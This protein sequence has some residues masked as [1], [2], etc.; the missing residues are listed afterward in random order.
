MRLP[1]SARRLHL[2]GGRLG[3]LGLERHALD[4]RDRGDAG[5]DLLDAVIPQRAGAAA[6]GGVLDLRGGGARA[7]ELANFVIEHEQLKGAEA[8]AVSRLA[9]VRA[10]GAEAQWFGKPGSAEPL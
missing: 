3:K 1:P 10:T 7:H 6:Q 8:P 9:A 4:L 5:Q 2:R